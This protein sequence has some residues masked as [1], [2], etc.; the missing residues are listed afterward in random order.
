M[1]LTGNTYTVMNIPGRV[2]KVFTTTEAVPFDPQAGRT[3]SPPVTV[4][5]R[6]TRLVSEHLNVPEELVVPEANILED[7]A[8]DSLDTVEMI[9]AL[10]EAFHIEI[11]DEE[12]A[13]V[14]TVREILEM[15]QKKTGGLDPSAGWAVS[16]YT[17]GAHP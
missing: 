2:G 4:E 14:R 16:A 5:T 12:S 7:L 11:P 3:G 8:A 6:I 17:E 1:A 9:L 13:T 15:I 10:E